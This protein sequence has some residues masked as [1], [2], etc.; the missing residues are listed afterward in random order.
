[1]PEGSENVNIGEPIA[2]VVENKEDIA[3]F[4]KRVIRFGDGQILSDVRKEAGAC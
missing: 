4:A 1:M 3:A 2:I